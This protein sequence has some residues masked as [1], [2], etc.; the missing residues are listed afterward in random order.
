MAKKIFSV[1]GSVLSYLF[2]ALCIF[3]LLVSV[4]SKKD[5]DGAANLFGKQFRIVVSDSMA[6]CDQ[7]DVS[8]YE[9]KDI[10]VKSLVIIDLVPEDEEEAKAWYADLEENDVLTFRYV[11]VRQ[12]TITHR[13]TDITEKEGGYVIRLEGDN[14]GSNSDTL[15][16]EIDTTLTD[17]PNYVVGKVV[18][19]SH[20]AGILLTAVK[21]PVG[22]ICIII[23]PC[24]LIMGVEIY[25]LINL[26]T[27]KK[28]LAA[29]KR[30]LDREQE[31]EE[32]K[33]QLSLLQGQLGK[34]EINEEDQSEQDEKDPTFPD[35]DCD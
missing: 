14:K 11:Y 12:E 9:I 28:R 20:T 24:L 17:S 33:K 22:I 7:T 30:E 19:V 26:L 3:L 16:Q 10:P 32:L 27:E 34:R 18:A 25:R 5:S 35:G 29:K 31:L 6:K 1:I 23:I 8:D 4:S 21:S 13:I 15:V 2:F